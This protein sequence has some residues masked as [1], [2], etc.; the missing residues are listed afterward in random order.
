M[1]EMKK[2][3][4][5]SDGVRKLKKES[6]LLTLSEYNS[7]R[8]KQRWSKMSK[9]QRSVAMREVALKGWETR[10]KRTVDKNA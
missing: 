8:S 7:L 3:L 2:L 6:K 4:T 5:I 9:K 10:R 1:T